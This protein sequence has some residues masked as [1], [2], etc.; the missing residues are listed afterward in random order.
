MHDSKG[1]SSTQVHSCLTIVATC[2]AHSAT[3]FTF[4]G[5]SMLR[6]TFPQGKYLLSGSHQATLSPD[7][8]CCPK[9]PAAFYHVRCRKSELCLLIVRNIYVSRGCLLSFVQRQT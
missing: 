9:N 6:D 5:H 2:H 4:P 3:P 7:A 8:A 1:S